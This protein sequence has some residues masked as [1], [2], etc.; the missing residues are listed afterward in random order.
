VAF[1]QSGDAERIELAAIDAGADDI[2][3]EDGTVEIT[4]APGDLE[5]VRRKLSEQKIAIASAETAMIPTSTVELDSKDGG[6]VLR[7]LERLEELDDVQRVYSN[8]EF[9]DEV[10]AELQS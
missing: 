8:A 3:S 10:L 9:P 1:S 2:R 6:Q 4:T 5:A 7:L